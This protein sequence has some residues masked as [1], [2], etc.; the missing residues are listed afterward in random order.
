MKTHYHDVQNIWCRKNGQ[1]IKNNIRPLLYDIDKIPPPDY[2]L[3]ENYLLENNRIIP[4]SAVEMEKQV[5]NSLFSLMVKHPSYMTLSGRGC[6][7]NC[8]YCCN[9]S[10][11]NLYRGQRYLRWRS[12]E[13][14]IGE[15]SAIKKRFPYIQY[16]CLSDDSFF[17]RGIDKI[18]EFCAAYKEEI[19]MPFYCLGSPMT[20]TEEKLEYLVDAGLN[21]IQMGIETGSRRIQEV[22]NRKYMTNER[23]MKAIFAINK[24]KDKLSLISYDFIL[25]VP[26]ETDEDKVETLEFISRIPK[27]YKIGM[28]SLVVYP[29]TSLYERIKKDNLIT[30]EETEIYHKKWSEKEAHYLNLLFALCRSGKFP[31]LLLRILISKPLLL[32]FNNDF[33]KP[34]YK[35][36]FLLLKKMNYFLKLLRVF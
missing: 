34:A 20:I 28:F 26:Y 3:V 15:L 32:V 24:Y 25:D 9:D 36:L 1:I 13:H 17:A 12:T 21:S 27:P 5:R 8:T 30:D 2:D 6:P 16:F 10:L 33:L 22:F 19:H 29:G 4:I 7:H 35:V 23:V 18:K 14:I 31:H 11:R